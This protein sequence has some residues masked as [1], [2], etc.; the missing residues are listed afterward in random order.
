[1][2]V[3]ISYL[4]YALEYSAPLEVL[5]V[6]GIRPRRCSRGIIIT[7]KGWTASTTAYSFDELKSL[8]AVGSIPS[9]KGG[10]VRWVCYCY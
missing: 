7:N 9:P 1:M 4:M 3:D 8:V 6:D 10:I 2:D 5:D